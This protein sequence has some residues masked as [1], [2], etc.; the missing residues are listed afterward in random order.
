L[1]VV[2]LDGRELG[3]VKSVQ[4]FGAGELIEVTRQGLQRCAEGIKEV[5]A[6]RLGHA[7]AAVVRGT[8]ADADD[9]NG[10]EAAGELLGSGFNFLNQSL[11]EGKVREAVL[12]FFKGLSIIYN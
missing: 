12:A 8:A 6:E 1:R 11:V 5:V 7:C 2:H 9:T 4:N 3:A 10:V